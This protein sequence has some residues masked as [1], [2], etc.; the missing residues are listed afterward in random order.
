MVG[1]IQNEDLSTEEKK[2]DQK[3]IPFMLVRPF[4]PFIVKSELPKEL[5]DDYNEELE[6]II[7]DKKL[8]SELDWSQHLVGKVTQELRVPDNLREK[9]DGYFQALVDAYVKKVSDDPK[10]RPFNLGTAWFVRQFPGEFNPIHIHTYCTL[11]SV[12]YLQ[13]P[14]GMDKEF[15]K[16]SK[17]RRP[18]K[19]HIE[20]IYGVPQ[21]FNSHSLLVQPKIGDFYIFPRY[22]MHTVYPFRT[23][24]ERRSFSM[25]VSVKMEEG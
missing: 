8:V 12:G 16:E 13:L 25:N 19:G 21:D 18:V 7:K 5:M 10:G 3:E 22:L 23:P 20:F 9:Y 24:G 14:K 2:T 4:G 6:K 15:E 17:T 1:N 11:S